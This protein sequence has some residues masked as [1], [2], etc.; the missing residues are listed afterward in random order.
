MMTS[1]FT[2]P[3][4]VVELHCYHRIRTVHAST[5]TQSQA[6]FHIYYGKQSMFMK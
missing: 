5:Y 3:L 6:V 1:T 4:V 2:E